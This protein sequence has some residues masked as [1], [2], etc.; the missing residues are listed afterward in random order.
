VYQ[1]P[2]CAFTQGRKDGGQGGHNSPG[3][4]SI[5][6]RRITAGAAKCLL[7]APKSPNNFTSTFF[8]TVNFLPKGL[9]FEHEGA[10]LATCP[11]RRLTS[12]RPCLHSLVNSIPRYLNVL[13]C[14]NV[15][16]LTLCA[17]YIG[18]AFWKQTISRSF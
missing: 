3:A 1:S 14:C 16:P 13:T 8:N 11:G 15:L 4:G 6:G 7:V 18:L 17:A 10:K 9:R 2:C 5:W 12:L